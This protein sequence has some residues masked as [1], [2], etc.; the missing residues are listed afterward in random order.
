MRKRECALVESEPIE[1]C[2]STVSRGSIEGLAL[3]RNS[4]LP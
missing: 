2:K 1:V 4:G 3:V